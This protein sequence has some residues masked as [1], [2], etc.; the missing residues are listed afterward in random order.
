M[1]NNCLSEV[2]PECQKQN[3]IL[4]DGEL[5]FQRCE[6]QKAKD[7]FEAIVHD[8]S[9]NSTDLA[10][11]YDL[12]G[13]VYVKLENYNEAL[14]NYNK[15]LELLRPPITNKTKSN[16]AK[17]YMSIGMIHSLKKEYSEALNCH[18]EALTIVFE[19]DQATDL[20]SDIYQNIANIYTRAHDFDGALSYFEKTLDFNAKHFSKNHMK[21]GR[22]YANMGAMYYAK[23]DYMESLKHFKKARYTLRRSLSSTHVY[24]KTMEKTIRDV[25]SKLSMYFS[26]LLKII[27][28]KL[29][30]KRVGKDSTTKIY[31]LNIH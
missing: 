10:R 5:L 12:L 4:S 17:C 9:I 20:I 30:K 24:I 31:D 8:S 16:M 13:A 23:G 26:T 29:H 7:Y 2:T 11:C 6:Y 27:R 3:N 1:S 21:F 22:T 18:Q 28:N 14:K 19:T 25:E 15:Q